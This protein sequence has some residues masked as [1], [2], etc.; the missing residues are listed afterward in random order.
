MNAF[1][2]AIARSIPQAIRFLADGHGRAQVIAGGTDLL[3]MMKER[4]TEPDRLV[5]INHIPDL[6]GILDPGP[7]GSFR[8]GALARLER[9]R[10]HPDVAAKYPLLAEAI[11]AI[12]TP[13][14]R[15]M[16]T[17]G[18]NLCQRPRCW[19]LRGLSF[20][21]SRKGGSICY[22]TRGE[23]PYHAILGG[24]LCFIVHP[25]DAAP[26]L[27]ALDARANLAGPEGERSLPL[28]EFFIGPRVEITKENVLKPGEILTSV[29]LPAPKTTARGRYVKLT[30]RGAWDFALASAAVWIDM[31]EGACREA[32]ICLGGVA[33]VPW[34]AV[35]AEKLLA[36][37]RI[38]GGVAAK[39]AEAALSGNEPLSGNAYK[40]RLAK[41][42]VR[43]ALLAAAAR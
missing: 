38:D 14:I 6:D 31:D 2:L 33:P 28:Q 29:T 27:V 18:G 26:A 39:A 34:R 13:Q 7:D 36:G 16:A 32:R 24:Y 12:A 37:R 1:E 3:G 20:E 5:N 17:L 15:N 22:A 4:L 30:Q 9:I 25:S 19:Y 41:T 10:R 8:I 11:G 42:A 21:C 43:R 35:E 23:N 40:V